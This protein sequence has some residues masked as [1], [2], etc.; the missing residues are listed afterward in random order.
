MISLRLTE[1]LSDISKKINK[2][3]SSD[4]NQLLRKQSKT[5]ENKCKLL[6]IDWII[7][8]PEMKALGNGVLNGP[9][10]LYP[11][12]N[13]RALVAI[14]HAVHDSV[15][16]QFTSFDQSMGKGKLAINFQPASFVNLLGLTE[17]H[18]IYEKGD[19]HWLKWMLEYGDRVIVTG[20]NYVKSSNGRSGF[21]TMKIAGSF[22]V[23]PQF[24]GTEEDNF[25]TRALIGQEQE[26]Q[27]QSILESVLK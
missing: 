19:L 6:A 7:G 2:A 23:P 22:R 1:S 18:V 10:G 16:V 21:G 25:I 3:I 15:F 14:S 27:I 20:Y 9:F 26:K 4:V 11:G 24:S 17:G 13:L 8:C 12:D 5:I